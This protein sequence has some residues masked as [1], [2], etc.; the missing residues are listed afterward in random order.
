MTI[1]GHDHTVKTYR[2][3]STKHDK[4]GH[5]HP[6]GQNVYTLSTFCPTQTSGL[7]VQDA[8]CWPSHHLK[9][10]DSDLLELVD[11]MPRM[12]F[13]DRVATSRL[14]TFWP[15]RTCGQSVQGVFCWPSD[16]LKVV[17]EPACSNLSTKCPG[18]DMLTEWPPQG[19]WRS[20]LLELVDLVPRVY[21]VD[22][23]TTLKLLMFWPTRIYRLSDYLTPFDFWPPS[24]DHLKIVDVLTSNLSMEC[25]GCIMLTDW[26]P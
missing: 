15:A 12:R 4:L 6:G 9:V 16:H 19:C 18:C 20:G 5:G 24:N 25:S 26:P 11:Q 7:S 10:V 22:Q 14:S 1:I 2:I 8:F 17:Y 21:F 23:V 3:R 13:V